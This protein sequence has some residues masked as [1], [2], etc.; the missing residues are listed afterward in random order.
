MD[1]DM[2]R[3]EALRQAV[4]AHNRDP[5]ADRIVETAKKFYEFLSDKQEADSK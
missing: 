4:I 3:Q 5:S 2:L 1:E